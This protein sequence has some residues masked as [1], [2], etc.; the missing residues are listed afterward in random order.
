MMHF[1]KVGDIEYGHSHQFDHLTLLASGKLKVTVNGESSEF[2]AP[3]MIYINKDLEHEL[4]ALEDNTIAYCIHALRDGYST[5]DII[6][7]GSIPSGY[8]KL[9]Q[10]AKDKVVT[11]L[12][13]EK[14]NLKSLKGLVS[15]EV[16]EI[17]KKEFK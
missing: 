4:V 17:P 2:T 10:L 6:D 12:I 8:S 5:E 16:N 14:D 7:P 1:E 11:K 13:T 3:N 9:S 15:E